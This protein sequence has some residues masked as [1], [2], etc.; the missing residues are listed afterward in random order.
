MGPAAPAGGC[1]TP[2]IG[3]LFECAIDSRWVGGPMGADHQIGR[4]VY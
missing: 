2:A 1:A 3:S 4:K